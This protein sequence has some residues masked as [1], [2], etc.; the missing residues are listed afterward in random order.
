MRGK[1]ASLNSII[2]NSP[3]LRKE[4]AKLVAEST[5]TIAKKPSNLVSWTQVRNLGSNCIALCNALTQELIEKCKDGLPPD[6]DADQ[7]LTMSQAIASLYATGLD[8]SGIPK[9][10]PAKQTEKKASAA[11]WRRSL[12]EVEAQARTPDP[13]PAPTAEESPNDH[14]EA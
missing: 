13:D 4:I 12:V 6:I 8:A 7:L 5:L 1:H 10:A 3:D 14:R 2:A 11:D 9:L